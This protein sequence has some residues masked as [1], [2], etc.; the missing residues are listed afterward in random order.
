MSPRSTTGL[1]RFGWA[2]CALLGLGAALAAQAQA[3]VVSAGPDRLVVPPQTSVRLT[4]QY[5]GAPYSG[6]PSGVTITWSQAD[7]PAATIVDGDTM[8]PTVFLSHAGTVHIRLKIFDPRYGFLGDDCFIYV[9]G[10]D[11]D[12]QVS[13]EAREWQKVQLSF[14][15]DAQMSETGPVNPFLDF[16]LV[17]FFLHLPT[18]TVRAIPGYYAA[19]GNAAE[20]SATSGNVWKVNFVPDRPGTWHYIASF[21][22]GQNIALSQAFQAGGPASFDNANGTLYVEPFDPNAPGFLSK[23][24]LDYTGE[25]HLRFAGTGAAFLKNGAG[26][27]ENFFAYYEFDGTSDQGGDA[28]ALNNFPPFDGLHHFD[29]HLADYVDLGVPLWKNGKG[30]RIFGAI[31]YLASRGVNSLFALSYNVD[32][33][34]GQE[35]WPWVSPTDKLHFDVS[36]L[37]QWERVVDHMQRAGITWQ[38]ITQEM[39]NDHALDGGGLGV[40]RKLYYRELVARF[41]HALGLVWNL[42]EENTN[43]PDER[44]AFADYIR[45]IDP[46]RHPISIHNLVGDIPG[47]FGTLLGTHLEMVSIQGDPTNTPPRARQLVLDSEAAGR[48]WVVNFD[49]QSPAQNGVVPDSVDFWHDLIRR[50][51]LWPMLLG[52]GGGCAWYF[53]YGHPNTDLDCENFRSRD[54]HFLLASRAIEFLRDH[55]PFDRMTMGDALATGTDPSVLAEPGEFYVVYLPFGGPTTLDLQGFTGDFLVSWFDA[56]NGGPLVNGDVTLVSGPGVVSLG[57]PPGPGDWAA[58]V[59][60][61]LNQPPSIVS[62]SVFPASAGGGRDFSLEVYAQDPNG[63]S[64]ALSVTAM[65]NGP[66]GAPSSQVTLQHV[67]GR[68]Y[69]FFLPDVPTV[70]PGT[71][72]AVVT[73]QDAAGAS[74]TQAKT[75]RV[76]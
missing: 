9:L 12:A 47:T 30:K 27:P 49:E 61:T 76:E 75:F 31:N 42:G 36:K 17:V 5:S 32:G 55:V 18:A 4:G 74:V 37:A 28:T 38:V 66:P 73:V 51:S 63:P 26:S 48:P 35:I 10:E 8:R 14:E 15:H 52:Q 11:Q 23:G 16:R 20:T 7:G 41:G 57:T 71:W 67:G 53:G 24:R 6:V 25:H 34:D 33:G 68:L 39:E 62:I 72:Q 69:S 21:R 13:G 56:R 45:K 3:P 70:F 40:E 19:D 22:T 64:D 46:Y 29:S 44:R 2:L 65:L 1:R 59:R 58:F 50:E 43:T 54:N 60:G